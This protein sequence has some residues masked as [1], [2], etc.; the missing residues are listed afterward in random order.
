[1][2]T[3]PHRQ[4]PANDRVLL[5][6]PPA[7]RADQTLSYAALG[8]SPRTAPV[9]QSAQACSPH[10]YY[11]THEYYTSR[12]PLPRSRSPTTT[13]IPTLFPRAPNSPVSRRRRRRRTASRSS[14]P[15]RSRRPRTPPRPHHPAPPR[16]AS[17]TFATTDRSP[18]RDRSRVV[19][20]DTDA[21]ARGSST[22]SAAAA[23]TPRVRR[24]SPSSSSPSSS[25]DTRDARA[26]ACSPSSRVASTCVGRTVTDTDSFRFDSIR[27]D[28]IRFECDRAEIFHVTRTPPR[29]DHIVCTYIQCVFRSKDSYVCVQDVQYVQYTQILYCS[30]MVVWVCMYV[31][32]Y[33][34]YVQYVCMYTYVHV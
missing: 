21:D 23:R 13:R 30:T 22:L 27:F 34:Q 15:T 26:R 5:Q 16:R 1:M 8:T 10:H 6:I 25:R 14:L 7:P 29:A 28:S 17:T 3:A 32:M 20:V 24:P 19:A 11:Y 9:A 33:V 18:Q 12:T 31:C 2:Y 4:Q